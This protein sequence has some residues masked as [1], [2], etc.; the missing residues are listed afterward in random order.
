MCVY[1]YIYIYK[2]A[3]YR[4]PP[5]ARAPIYVYIYISMQSTTR[6]PLPAAPRPQFG[7]TPTFT[8]YDMITVWG[9]SLFHNSQSV[10]SFGA[11][12]LSHVTVVTQFGGAANFVPGG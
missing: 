5:A 2:Y 8:I 11:L 3:V 6:L 10:H 4:P 9:Y 1:T 7:G 12:P